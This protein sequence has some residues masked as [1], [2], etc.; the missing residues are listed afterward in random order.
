[1]ASFGGGKWK[2]TAHKNGDISWTKDTVQTMLQ[3]I[4]FCTVCS[5]QR[6]KTEREELPQK[7]SMETI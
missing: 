2:A 4:K 1:V 7:W 3:H 6:G 5:G